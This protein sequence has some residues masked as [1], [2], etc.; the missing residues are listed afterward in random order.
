MKSLQTTKLSILGLAPVVEGS[1]IEE[2]FE[3]TLDLAQHADQWGYHRFWLAEHHNM[4]GI[5]SSATS[6][7]IGY[8]A[9]GTKRIR[10]GAGG[11][12]LPNHSPLV[13]AEQFGTLEAMY[14]GRIDLG[15]GRAPGTDL[16]ATRALRRGSGQRG[17]DFPELL[18]ELRL[19]FKPTEQS[20]EVLPRAIPGEGYDIPIWLLGSSGFS[21]QLAAQ[22]GLP[23]AFASHFAPDYLIPALNLYHTGFQPSETLDKPYS[24]VGV[25]VIV[26]DTDDEAQFLA[27]SHQQ[28]FLGIIRN[29]RGLLK[30]P[31]AD[32]DQL[33]DAREKKVIE[34]QLSYTVV[35]NQETVKKRLE[36]IIAETRADELI[37]ASQIYD[38][39]ATLYSYQL[40]AEI[41]DE[42]RQAASTH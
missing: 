34:S 36:E 10:V 7:V 41:S 5:A 23:F 25:N 29:Q 8:V 12:M 39:Q 22:L 15:L 4:P 1:S 6:V 16:L 32:M 20:R 28:A 42:C 9:A 37:V 38:H 17:E 27:T 18:H 33:W 31:V 2:A 35:G 21:A 11:I 24:M 26:A 19:Y 3:R 13:I 14:P 30:P 40:L